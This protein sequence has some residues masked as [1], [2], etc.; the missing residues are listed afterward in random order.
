MTLT[1][2]RHLEF[3]C[4]H[5]HLEFRCNHFKLPTSVFFS[6]LYYDALPDNQLLSETEFPFTIVLINYLIRKSYIFHNT[7]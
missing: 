3:R 6:F 4:N 2:C 1:I 7:Q 5:F